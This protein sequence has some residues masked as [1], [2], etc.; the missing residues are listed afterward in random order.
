[1]SDAEVHG[2]GRDGPADLRAAR[3]T[4]AARKGWKVIW[5]TAAA[6][7]VTRPAASAPA[8]TLRGGR[9]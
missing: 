6:D 4:L 9:A 5:T 8:R 7:S 3:R 2:A 1:M